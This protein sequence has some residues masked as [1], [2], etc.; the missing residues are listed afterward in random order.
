MEKYESYVSGF[1]ARTIQC[2]NHFGFY[3]FVKHVVTVGPT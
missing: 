1:E 2:M 3:S